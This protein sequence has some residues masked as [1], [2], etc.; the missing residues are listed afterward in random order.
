MNAQLLAPQAYGNGL[1]AYADAENDLARGRDVERIRTRLNT[2]TSALN[3][4]TETAKIATITLA[5]LIKTRNDAL[6]SLADNF[7][8]DLWLEAED[9]LNGASRRLESGDIEG[10]RDRAEAAEALF[11]D[12]EL[13]SIKAQYLSHTRAL[14]AL[15]DQARVPRYAP[16]TYARSSMRIATTRICLSAY[17]RKLTTK[18]GGQFI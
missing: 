9:A 3:E 2:A 13:T 15:A 8:V 7:A 1:S 11:R 10:A 4:A 18:L 5:P 6:N 14:L 12:A 16:K 17:F